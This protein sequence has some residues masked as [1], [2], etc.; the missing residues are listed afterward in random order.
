MHSRIADLISNVMRPQH[1]YIL[2]RPPDARLAREIRGLNLRM[3]G[4][5]LNTQ[6][7]S[8][9]SAPPSHCDSI[10]A[11]ILVLIPRIFGNRNCTKIPFYTSWYSNLGGTEYLQMLFFFTR[12]NTNNSHKEVKKVGKW[13]FLTVGHGHN[14]G[15]NTIKATWHS[16]IFS[17]KKDI[18]E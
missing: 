5:T 16:I 18:K 10:D 17:T 8:L 1:L 14:N 15:Q 13:W 2:S 9:S 6:N 11:Q 12:R 3:L 7:L 4:T